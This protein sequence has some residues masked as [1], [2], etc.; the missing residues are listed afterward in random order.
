MTLHTV[1]HDKIKKNKNTNAQSQPHKQEKISAKKAPTRKKQERGNK[2]SIRSQN[3]ENTSPSTTPNR[4]WGLEEWIVISLSSR[5]PDTPHLMSAEFT[6]RCAPHFHSPTLTAPPV[7][8][9]R[10]TV[11]PHL[12]HPGPKPDG[13]RGSRC[14]S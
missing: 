14:T 6:S 4:P 8:P 1:Y 7:Q 5:S 9:T 11:P 10:Q 12:P 3:R 2:R 13:S